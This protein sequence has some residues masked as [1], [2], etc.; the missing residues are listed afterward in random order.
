M[1]TRV[2]LEDNRRQYLCTSS[3]TRKMDKNFDANRKREC[4]IC[5]YDLHFSAACCPCSMDRYSCLNHVKQLCSCAWSEK[6]FLFRFSISDLNVLIEAL[7]GKLSAVYRWAREEL[8]LSLTPY[9]SKDTI[10]PWRVSNSELHKEESKG[11]E[12][13]FQCV[14]KLYGIERSTF[15][16]IK[17]EVKA[18]MLQAR[19]LNKQKP[20]EKSPVSEFATSAAADYDSLILTSEISSESTSSSSSSE[21]E[22]DIFI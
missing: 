6:I 17:E 16:S 13:Q 19:S 7:E 5:F 12:H 4:S 10:A 1:Q 15:S 14:A 9:I 18:R 8:Q 11:K 20:K 2:K 3:Q 22:Q 21:L